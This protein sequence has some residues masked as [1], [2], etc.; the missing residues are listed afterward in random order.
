MKQVDFDLAVQYVGLALCSLGINLQDENFE[1]TPER[2][3]KYLQEY[4]NSDQKAEEVLRKGFSAPLYKGMIAQAKIPFR[5]IC[6]HH[7]LPVI[8]F[9]NIGYVPE[10]RV[11]GLSKLAR[12]VDLVG[13]EQ[14][15]MQE[16]ITDILADMLMKELGAL[17][18]IVVIS[19]EHMCMAGRGVAVHEVPTITSSVRGVLKDNPPARQEFFDLLR[20]NH[21]R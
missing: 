14:P 9:A 20:T 12:I 11:V 2:F 5:T 16:S 7:L 6:P 21:I 18:A 1:G 13:R 8:G 4:L 10:E 15:R 17:G 3:V 19:A